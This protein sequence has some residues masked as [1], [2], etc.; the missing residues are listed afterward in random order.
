MPQPVGRVLL[1]QHTLLCD[2]A[3]RR[4][5]E[6]LGGCR[7]GLTPGLTLLVMVCRYMQLLGL[8]PGLI[9]VKQEEE[10]QQADGAVKL[11]QAEGGRPVK[12]EVDGASH[13]QQAGG[14]P[15]PAM[16]AAPPAAGFGGL[17]PDVAAAFAAAAA[18]P[19]GSEGLPGP[20]ATF[21]TGQSSLPAASGA[22]GTGTE[23]SGGGAEEE[24]E[25]AASRKPMLAAAPATQLPP[26]AIPF[27][28]RLLE[29][30]KE[31]LRAH[32]EALRQRVEVSACD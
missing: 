11:E 32:W 14:L 3:E 2:G 6:P 23:L 13:Q 8:K 12:M 19:S 16:Q 28:P 5:A 21:G 26:S 7:P 20:S 31:E 4:R 10:Q 29:S 24:G 30:K 1:H 27:A 18:V 25:G 9:E 15:A 22:T 17:P